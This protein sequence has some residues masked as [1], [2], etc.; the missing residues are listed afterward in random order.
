MGASIC[1]VLASYGASQT[2]DHEEWDTLNP[3]PHGLQFVLL[4]RKQA[5][6]AE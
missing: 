5:H 2:E 4:Y 6:A 1:T 3:I